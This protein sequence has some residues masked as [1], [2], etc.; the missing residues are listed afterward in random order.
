MRDESLAKRI[1]DI[2][3]AL[4]GM[5][6]NQYSGGGN[7]VGY[8]Y[9]TEN[10]WDANETSTKT[11]QFNYG[12]NGTV[13]I[14]FQN[15]NNPAASTAFQVDVLINDQPW[16]TYP[17]S[18]VDWIIYGSAIYQSVPNKD[19]SKF[20][21]ESSVSFGAN[22]GINVK[23]KVRVISLDKGILTVTKQVSQ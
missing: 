12:M 7:T 5:K 1:S 3:S 17:T 18:S 13:N 15:L 21:T 2:N 4:I 20:I 23:V 9:E 22:A 11:G 19:L 16:Y 14:K 8:A 6:S 10:T